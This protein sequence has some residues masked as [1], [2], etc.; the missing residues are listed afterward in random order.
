MKIVILGAGQVG[1]STAEILAA[2]NHDVSLVDVDSDTLVRP[3]EKSDIQTVT[4]NCMFPEVLAEAGAEDAE[5][6][7]AVTTSDEV[8]M[9][10]CQIAHTLFST[11]NKVARIRAPSF[12]ANREIFNDKSIPIDNIISPEEIVTRQVVRLIEHPGALQVL[13]FADGKIQLVAIRA[14]ANSP[15]VNHQIKDLKDHLPGVDSRVAAIYRGDRSVPA[16]GDTV[17]QPDDEVFFVAAREHIKAVMRELHSEVKPTRRVMIAGAGNIGLRLAKAVVKRKYNCKII[18]RDKKRGEEVTTILDGMLVLK[19][20]AADEEMLRE[21]NIESFD[22][23]CSVTNDDEANILSAMLAKRL[24]VRTVIA[25]VNRPSY[26]EL[27]EGTG[28]DIA[29]APRTAT[30]GTLL[31]TIRR[32]DMVAVH[33]LRNGAAEAI[34]VIA[35]GDPTTSKVVGRRVGEM[36]LPSGTKIGALLRGEEVVIAHDNVEIQENDH[37]ILFVTDKQHI[38]EVE[39]LFSVSPLSI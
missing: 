1:S 2:E 6:V 34:E 37:L 22:V 35:H 26:T 17:V 27:I 28:V 31:T 14:E 19:G 18:E 10:A 8:N 13:D 30:V 4:G 5:L 7:M 24:G 39:Q 29:I 33:S 3:G 21:E 20:D 16:D 36:D 23:F 9:V 32:G 11:P 25:L 38:P 12:L 15:I